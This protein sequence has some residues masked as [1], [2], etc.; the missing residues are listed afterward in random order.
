MCSSDLIH[1]P[2]MRGGAQAPMATSEVEAKC[3]DNCLYGG[4]A[5]EKADALRGLSA[6]VFA[7]KDLAAMA[8]FRA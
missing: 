2:F 5:R 3:V 1:Q 4:W 8:E 6:K 7:A